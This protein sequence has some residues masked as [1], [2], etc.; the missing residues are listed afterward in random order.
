MSSGDPRPRRALT[1]AEFE[2]AIEH[3]KMSPEMKLATYQYMVLNKTYEDV[4]SMT[5]VH[6]RSI[7]RKV[8]EI[9]SEFLKIQ[10]VPA[11]WL[12]EMVTL[13]KA[14]MEIVQKRSAELMAHELGKKKR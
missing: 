4:A 6:D 10:P 9:W 13:P 2:R 5:K 11:G 12:R 1:H 8:R 7:Q 3:V 14:E